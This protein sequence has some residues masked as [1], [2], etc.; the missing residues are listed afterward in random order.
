VF[1]CFDLGER[2]FLTDGKGESLLGEGVFL[3]VRRGGSF[4]GEGVFLNVRRGGSLTVEGDFLTIASAF[5]II[6]DDAAV[7][8]FTD[9]K[10]GVETRVFLDTTLAVLLLATV[11]RAF[12]IWAEE[13]DVDTGP[14]GPIPVGL[15]SGSNRL[16]SDEFKGGTFHWSK[17]L[18]GLF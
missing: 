9:G 6:A 13:S 17:L 8:V 14:A 3:N 7:L 5:C 12:C 18:L 4:L 11:R 10:T 15:P 16:P 2:V 1:P